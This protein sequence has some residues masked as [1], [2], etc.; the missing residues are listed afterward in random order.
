MSH[1]TRLAPA[2]TRQLRADRHPRRPHGNPVVAV[3]GAKAKVDESERR[4]RAAHNQA[5][6]R[7]VNERIEE[8]SDS[9]GLGPGWVCECSDESCDER[10]GLTIDEYERVRAHATHFLVAPGHR[11]P[12]VDRVVEQGERYW[13]VAKIEEGADVARETDPR[14]R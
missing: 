6:F 3:Q 1:R 2:L 14:G 9:P 12:R 11:D 4:T 8:L 5:L 7:E 13:I 10:I